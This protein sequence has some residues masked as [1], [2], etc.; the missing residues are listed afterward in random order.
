MSS[1]ARAAMAHS[2]GSGER[3]EAEP[4]GTPARAE[5]VLLG[6]ER[7]GRRAVGAGR[8]WAGEEVHLHATDT[9]GAELDVADA[10]PVVGRGLLTAALTRDQRRGDDACRSL[11]E[12][13]G[14]R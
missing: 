8:L 2:H 5:A 12:H 6:D 3:S 1:S 4:A 11:G 13:A 7:F 9:T 14:L 10:D